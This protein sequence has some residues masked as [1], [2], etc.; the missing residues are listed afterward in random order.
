MFHK[1]ISRPAAAVIMLIFGF[2][3]DRRVERDI[4]SV[5]R[6]PLDIV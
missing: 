3:F 4:I 2:E 6:L 1:S 5:I